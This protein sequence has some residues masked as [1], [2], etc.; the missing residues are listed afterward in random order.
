MCDRVV[1]IDKGEI[2]AAGTVAE[3]RG[4]ATGTLEDIFLSLT[5][6]AEYAS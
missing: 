1:I 3:L 5:G 6:G 2:V 4:D